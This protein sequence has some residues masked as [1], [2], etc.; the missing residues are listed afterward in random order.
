MT[1]PEHPTE[2]DRR[3]RPAAPS[4][5]LSQPAIPVA[6]AALRHEASLFAAAHGAGKRLAGDVALAVSEAVTNAVKYAYGPDGEGRV[7]LAA[8]VADGWLEIRVSDRGR[9]FQPGRSDGLGL[10]LSLIADL[11]AEMTVVQG[12]EGTEIR[13]RFA[14]A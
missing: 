8:A 5:A 12:P 7:Q 4:L 1:G 3:P 9:G 2:S 6:V 14:L 10:G 13:M 11:A